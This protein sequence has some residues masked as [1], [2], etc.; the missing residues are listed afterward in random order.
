MVF[1]S[2]NIEKEFEKRNR[3]EWSAKHASIVHN[4]QRSASGEIVSRPWVY[5]TVG[6]ALDL[7]S[8]LQKEFE[9][10]GDLELAFE[11]VSEKL[12]KEFKDSIQSPVYNW[13]NDT[14]RSNGEYITAGPRNI[15][16]SSEL[17]NSQKQTRIR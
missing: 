8:E 2:W 15:V 9:K 6:S 10:T 4:G 14:K 13:P 7:Q 3:Y 5:K 12:N 16:D 1:L 11:A 17:I